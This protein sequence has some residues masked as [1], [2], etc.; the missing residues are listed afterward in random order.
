LVYNIKMNTEHQI[1]FDFR[2]KSFFL[3]YP[4]ADLDKTS[5]LGHLQD[6]FNRHFKSKLIEYV[7]ARELH[8]DGNPHMHCFILLDRECR[9]KKDVRLFDINGHHPNIQSTRSCKAVVKYCTK[10]EDYLTNIEKKVKRYHEEELNNRRQIAEEL[11]KGKK[12]PDLV[13]ANPSL[14]FGYARLKQDIQS[15]MLDKTKPED[16]DDVCGLWIGGPSGS[17]KSTIAFTRFGDY[18]PKG[19]NKWWCGYNGE[20]TV[21]LDDVDESWKDTLYYWKWWFGKWSFLGETKNGTLRLRPRK[22]IVTS[23]FTLDELLEKWGIPDGERKP[24]QRRFKSQYWITSEADWD[25]QL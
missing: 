5:V 1:Y 21:V 25:D 4:Q 3:T 7:I 22:V 6:L 24:Y 8:E 2:G 15:Y 18:Y 23:N 9:A 13:E 16:L 14:L 10:K 11:L 20:G 19:K 17:G 12:L